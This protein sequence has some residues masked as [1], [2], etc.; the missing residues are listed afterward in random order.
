LGEAE[1][2]LVVVHPP[3][4]EIFP[5]LIAVFDD[6]QTLLGKPVNRRVKFIPF[7]RDGI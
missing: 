7:D 1:Q 6:R 5:G 2:T 3:A 4:S